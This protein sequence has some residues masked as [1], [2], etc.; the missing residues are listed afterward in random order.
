M[1]IN[2]QSL[3]FDLDNQEGNEILDQDSALYLQPP[4]FIEFQIADEG[5]EVETHD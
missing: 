3:S 1:I 5:L 4:N 2:Q